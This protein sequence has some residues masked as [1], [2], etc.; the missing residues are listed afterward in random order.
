MRCWCDNDNGAPEAC[1][2]DTQATPASLAGDPHAD[3]VDV[4]VRVLRATG[5]AVFCT[6]GFQEFW[7]PVNRIAELSHDAQK[8]HVTYRVPMW[9]AIDRGLV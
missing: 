2:V 4:Q 8:G 1:G 3:S 5:R 6:D 9:L 7:L